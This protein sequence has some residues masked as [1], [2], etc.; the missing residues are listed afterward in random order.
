MFCDSC[1]HQV[2]ESARFCQ[3]CGRQFP[4]SP[5]APTPVPSPVTQAIPAKGNTG[6]RTVGLVMVALGLCIVVFLA[7]V[8][9]S[10]TSHSGTSRLE[11][12]DQSE[13]STKQRPA[14]STP[15]PSISTPEAKQP[16]PAALKA[17]QKVLREKWTEETQKDLWRQGVEMTF[18]AHGTTLYV[19]YVLAG[20]AF[21]FQFHDGFLHDNAETLKGLGF[22][23]VE[24]SNGDNVWSWKLSQ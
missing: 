21:A 16:D 22:K 10:G 19:K 6:P 2:P 3:N 23:A 17:A 24:L 12:S 14:I 9:R 11:A 4:L 15:S 13:P 1:G 18:Q 20:D 5:I 8:Q 7:T